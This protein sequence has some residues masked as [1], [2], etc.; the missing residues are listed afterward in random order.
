V[1]NSQIDF[2]AAFQMLDDLLGRHY[3]KL[4]LIVCGGYLMQRMGVRT[5]MD[6][7]A[8]Y[9]TS[10]DVQLLIKQAGALLNINTEAVWLNNAVASVNDWPPQEYCVPLY[11]FDYLT[12]DQVTEDYLLGMKLLASRQEDITDAGKII[13]A[14][15][16]RDP[17]LLYHALEQMGFA[18]SM[19]AVLEAFSIAYG[20]QWRATYWVEYAEKILSMRNI[21]W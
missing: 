6:V 14:K 10:K 11:H 20:D 16:L 13:N 12:V 21:N 18:L 2:E 7:D 9:T 8:F 17:V 5:T 19:V 3:M 4:H 1:G 15:Q